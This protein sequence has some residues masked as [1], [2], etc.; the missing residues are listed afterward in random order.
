MTFAAVSC[1]TGREIPKG[2]VPSLPSPSPPPL[3][4]PPLPDKVPVYPRRTARIAPA[5]PLLHKFTLLMPQANSRNG[6]CLTSLLLFL[7]SGGG[8]G[9]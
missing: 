8:R 5:H 3:L 1:K 9:G 4:S 6:A 2:S 7:T